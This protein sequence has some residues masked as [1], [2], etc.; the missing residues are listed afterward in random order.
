MIEGFAGCARLAAAVKSTGV[1]ALAVDWKGNKDK[2]SPTVKCL[3]IDLSTQYGLQE[4][5][6]LVKKE[7]AGYVAL[8]PPCGTSSLARNIR[9]FDKKRKRAQCDPPPLRSQVH[10]DGLPSLSGTDR[11]KVACANRTDSTQTQ[12]S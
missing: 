1:K 6:D 2:T 8:A 12:W 5:K 10:P 11:D 3:W 4:M 9:R 7:D